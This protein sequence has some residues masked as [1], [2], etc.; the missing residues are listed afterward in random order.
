MFRKPGINGGTAL[1]SE[2]LHMPVSQSCIYDAAAPCL[3]LHVGRSHLVLISW[4]TMPGT[5]LQ[6]LQHT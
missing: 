2:P 6:A 4:E 1:V 3:N 5:G